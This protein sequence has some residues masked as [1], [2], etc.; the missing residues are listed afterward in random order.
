MSTFWRGTDYPHEAFIQG[1]LE[2]HFSALGY[3]FIKEGHTDLVC[4]K[5]DAL[6][7]W[8]IEAKGVTDSI[9]LDFRTGLGQLV[10]GMRDRQVKYALAMPDIPK[11][12]VQAAKLAPWLREALNLHLIFVNEAGV[13]RVVYPGDPA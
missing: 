6:D 5:E 10:L 11:F 12:A 4:V 9:G 3:S 13:L 7:K 1:A 2:R 8:A